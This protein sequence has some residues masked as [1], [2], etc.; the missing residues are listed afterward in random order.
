[1]QLPAGIAIV[2]LIAGP[3]YFAE[4]ALHG[5]RF[6]EFVLGFLLLS[7]FNAAICGH[8]GPWY[9]YF[10]ALI[11]GFAPWSHFLPYALIRTWRNAQRTT[12]NA[13]LLTLCY[14]IPVFIVF[15]IAQTKLP[16][17]LLP[18]YP[19]LAIMVGKLWDDVLK[20]D[21]G[22][23]TIDHR[24]LKPRMLLSQ[25]LLILVV[26][27]LIIGFIIL[28]TSNYSGQYQELLPNLKLLAGVLIAGGLLSIVY[29]LWSKWKLS[30]AALPLMVFIIALI[31]T[32]QTLPAIEK[33]KGAKEL[34]QSIAQNLKEAESVASYNIVN[35]PGVVFYSP[36]L[37]TIIESEDEAVKFLKNKK[38]CLFTT[39]SA[40]EKIKTSLPKNAAILDQKGDLL[41]LY[42]P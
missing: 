30:F 34:G 35:K 1:M 32:T 18:L 12:Y 25:I 23:S 10:L 29:G 20:T 26:I 39:L 14:I 31:L 3:W 24:L 42:T 41:V 19:F 11:L 13:E 8:A 33:Y 6:T 36:R 9:Y 38:G 4:W 37:T 15:S 7:R 2:L 17:Y 21:H 27:L 5:A 16:N 40:Y 22:P 28:G